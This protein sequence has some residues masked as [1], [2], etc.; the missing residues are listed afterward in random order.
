MAELRPIGGVSPEDLHTQSEQSVAMLKDM[1]ARVR[2]G[3][4]CAGTPVIQFRD[5]T[6]P[7]DADL[8][9]KAFEGRLKLGEGILTSG[10]SPFHSDATHLSLIRWGSQSD[11][12]GCIDIHESTVLSECSFISYKSIKVGKGVLFGPGAVV[13][14]CDGAPLDPAQ[15]ISEDNLNIAPVVIEDHCWIGAYA[16]IMPGVTIG[17]HATIAGGSVVF[18]D[19]PPH[20]IAA[21]N[22][23][24]VLGKF[25]NPDGSPLE[26]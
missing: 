15:P 17:H 8:D 12:C 3:F 21:G 25:R 6:Q 11:Q 2:E 9:M 14:D 24:S 20:S 7:E 22:P 19:V 5:L 1:G 26:S 4:Y 10:M 23:A 18:K 13:M 16:M